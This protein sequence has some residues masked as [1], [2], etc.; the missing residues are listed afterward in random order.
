[1][2]PYITETDCGACAIRRTRPPCRRDPER[3]RR[4]CRGAR[5]LAA[6]ALRAA[7]DRFNWETQAELLFAEYGRLTGK[8]W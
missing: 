4:A 6:N 8:P 1:M 7:H 2:A 3:P 5:R